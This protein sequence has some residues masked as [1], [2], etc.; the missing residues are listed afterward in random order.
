MDVLYLEIKLGP[1]KYN[2]M[3]KA[4]IL[5]EIFKIVKY[6]SNNIYFTFFLDQSFCFFEMQITSATSLVQLILIN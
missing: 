2:L 1:T 6:Q 5:S 4:T 3:P